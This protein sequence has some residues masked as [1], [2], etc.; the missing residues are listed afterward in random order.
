MK[1]RAISNFENNENFLKDLASLKQY[2]EK[3]IVPTETNIENVFHSL[4]YTIV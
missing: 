3:D 4:K 2:I 1:F